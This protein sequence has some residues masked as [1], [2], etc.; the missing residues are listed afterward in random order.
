[1]MTINSKGSLDA[2]IRILRKDYRLFA[3]VAPNHTFHHYIHPSVGGANGLLALL[4]NNTFLNDAQDA[5][6]KV[7]DC[8]D[9]VVCTTVWVRNEYKD[10]FVKEVERLFEGD[11]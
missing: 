6:I 1:M 8:D 10:R 2:C 11:D 4:T 5:I 3:T 9:G 7:V